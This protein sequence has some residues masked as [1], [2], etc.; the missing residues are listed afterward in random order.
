[1]SVTLPRTRST[2]SNASLSTPQSD[3]SAS[4]GHL[5]TE[6]AAPIPMSPNDADGTLWSKCKAIQVDTP[7]P[8]DH[9]VLCATVTADV[10]ISLECCRTPW[11]LARAL[12]DCQLGWLGA[13]RSD[14]LHR[15]VSIGNLLLLKVPAA[16]KSFQASLPERYDSSELAEARTAY[17]AIGADLRK[18][19]D[20]LDV[21][22][23]CTAIMTDFD[24]AFRMD[25]PSDGT[26]HLSGTTEFMSTRM[27]RS[28]EL[29]T[30]YR[31]GVQDDLWS[32]FNVAFWAILHNKT[33][34]GK[35][36]FERVWG[37]D[38][39]GPY[40]HRDF[41]HGDIIQCWTAIRKAAKAKKQP[42][43]TAKKSG[44]AVPDESVLDEYSPLLKAFLPILYE[45]RKKL[46]DLPNSA[47]ESPVDI[48]EG[49][50]Q[51][52]DALECVREFAV[53]LEKYR[54]RLESAAPTAPPPH[55]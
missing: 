11:E 50:E 40:Q 36:S 20:S 15:D 46:L 43:L 1:M 3:P 25:Q 23:E 16:R 49:F 17:N 47:L 42:F 27:L 19:L 32:F 7:T 30:R 12:L 33:Y 6:S 41:A 44:P 48:A 35:S 29:G 10:G 22:D 13:L 34:P 54:G 14:I 4:T 26:G 8:P 53:I 18:T 45:W 39:R 31:Q 55:A 5:A 28:M 2:A 37:E 51:Q 38:I 9:R 52:Y 21:G 24:L